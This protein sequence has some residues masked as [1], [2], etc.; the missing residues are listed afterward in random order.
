MVQ[1]AGLLPLDSNFFTQFEPSLH[2][3]RVGYCVSLENVIEKHY[4]L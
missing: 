1:L 3:I 2:K 4:H